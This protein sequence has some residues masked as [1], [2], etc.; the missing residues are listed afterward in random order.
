MNAYKI[1]FQIYFQSVEQKLCKI[2]IRKEVILKSYVILLSL[3]ALNSF[4]I[5]IANTK[6]TLD[7]AEYEAIFFQQN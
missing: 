3:R 6:K 1:K 5:F 2:R 4:L 7:G